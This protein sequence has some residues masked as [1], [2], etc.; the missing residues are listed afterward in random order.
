MHD[1]ADRS[2]LD[3]SLEANHL[4]K[5]RINAPQL[6][7]LRVLYENTR[8]IDDNRESRDD[9]LRR[10]AEALLHHHP[11]KLDLSDLIRW[12]SDWHLAVVG[13]MEV[14]EL[15]LSQH[16]LMLLA[17]VNEVSRSQRLQGLQVLTLEGNKD[18]ALW[19]ERFRLAPF[20]ALVRPYLRISPMSKLWQVLCWSY[21]D[22]ALS[23]GTPRRF[24][25]L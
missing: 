8:E 3:R 15:V 10:E 21:H 24:T 11:C 13:R 18:N 5:L 25:P 23:E 7:S 20:P 1:P 9:V 22:C 16:H 19:E 6:T 17:I 2:C 4:R 12:E 14:R